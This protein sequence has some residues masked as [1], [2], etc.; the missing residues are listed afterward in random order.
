LNPNIDLSNDWEEISLVTL[1]FVLEKGEI[2]DRNEVD[3][4]SKD[5]GKGQ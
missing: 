1:G 4:E 3:E 5:T 2:G